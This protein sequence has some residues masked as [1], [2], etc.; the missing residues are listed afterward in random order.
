M[1]RA[2]QSATKVNVRVKTMPSPAKPIGTPVIAR[3]AGVAT[4]GSMATPVKTGMAKRAPMARQ[5]GMAV[6]A[7]TGMAKKKY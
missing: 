2:T 1:A 3:P 4:Q 6:P 7:K 5:G